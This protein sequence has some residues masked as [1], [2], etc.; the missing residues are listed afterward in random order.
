MVGLTVQDLLLIELQ[1]VFVV[2]A[3]SGLHFACL[4]MPRKHTPVISTM[5]VYV[6]ICSLFGSQITHSY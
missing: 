5:Q 2:K 6:A 4:H 3:I 1:S